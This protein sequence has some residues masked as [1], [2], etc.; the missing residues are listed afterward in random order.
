[1]ARNLA[2]SSAYS[3]LDHGDGDYDVTQPRAAGS[4]SSQQA[5]VA[6]ADSIL[7]STLTAETFKQDHFSH[8]RSRSVDVSL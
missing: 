2:D 3:S 6:E 7:E 8:E 1:M 5:E 4:T